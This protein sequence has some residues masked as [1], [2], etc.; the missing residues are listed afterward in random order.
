MES[1][2]ETAFKVDNPLHVDNVPVANLVVIEVEGQP[3]L[4]PTKRTAYETFVKVVD[5]IQIGGAV[6]LMFGILGALLV[7]MIWLYNPNVFG[8]S[9]DDN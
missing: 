6:L 3:I 4:E 8:K 7:F 1:D 9:N 2:V 5:Y